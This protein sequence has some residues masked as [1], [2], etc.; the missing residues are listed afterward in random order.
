MLNFVDVINDMNIQTVY[1][2]TG[3]IHLD[4]EKENN[5]TLGT[6][7]DCRGK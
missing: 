7:V 2:L 6:T 3:I 5:I 1:F 4:G